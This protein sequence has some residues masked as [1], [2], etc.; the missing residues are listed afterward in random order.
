[1]LMQM[2]HVAVETTTDGEILIRQDDRYG[3]EPAIVVITVEQADT[4]IAW[5]RRAVA[6]LDS[7]D[8]G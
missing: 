5:I 7:E 8:H 6:I 1:M 4:V 3:D 2:N